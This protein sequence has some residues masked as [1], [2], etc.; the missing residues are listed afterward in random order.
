M[1]TNRWRVGRFFKKA[2]ISVASRIVVAFAAMLL[3]TSSGQAQID[4]TGLNGTVTDA[5]GRVVPKAH[6]T[7]V[8]DGTGLRRETFSSTNGT[9]DI[10]ELP[11]GHYTVTFTS[12]GFE[13]LTYSNVI[14]AV[15]VTRTLNATLK[16][17]GGSQHIQ[18][19]GT[20]NELNETSASMGTRIERTQT[21]DLPLNGRNWATLTLLGPGATDTG[22]SGQRTIHVAGRSVDDNSYTFDG[23][24]ASNVMNQPQQAFVRLAIP[25]DTIEEFRVESALSTAETGS[26]PGG[27]IAVTSVAGSN[28]FHGDAFEYL[29]NDALDARNFFDFAGLQKYPFRLNQFGGSFGGPIK[30]NKTF[31]Y[32]TYEGLRQTLG[33][34]LS[35]FVPTAGYRAQLLAASP[36]LAPIINAY[37]QGQTPVASDP[38][39]IA[40][41]TGEGT[42]LDQ[43]DSFMIRVD[44]HF[45]DRT[46]MYGRFNWDSAISTVPLAGQTGQ[47]LADT[48]ST[49][50][51]PVNSVVELLHVF[52]ADLVN[53]TK[54]G[55][56]RS[57]VI[58]TNEN[59]DGLAYSVAV[60]NLTTENNGSQA[61]SAGNEFSTLDD[62][63]WIRGRH[64]L[65]LGAE[66]RRIQINE[67]NNASGSVTYASLLAFQTNQVSS[68]AFAAALPTNGLRKTS[69]FS[70][71]QDEFKLR[72]NI[73]LDMGLRYS[74]FNHFHEVDGRAIPFDFA[75]CGAQGFCPIGAD[76]GP[77]NYLDLDPRFSIAWAPSKLGRTAVIRAGAGIY[78]GDGQL[79]DQN[80]PESNEVDSYSLSLKTIPTLSFPITPFLANTPGIVSPKDEDR[81]RK[82]MYVS[83][84]GLS[85]EHGVP[86][87]M[88]VTVSYVGEQGTHLLNRSFVNVI[89]PLTGVRPYPAFGQIQYRGNDNNSSFE[90]LQTSLRR[91]FEHGLLLS[92]NYMWSHEID[93]DSAGAG[94]VYSQYPENVACQECERASGNF[95]IRH[96]FNANL[97]YSLPSP[98][99]SR[100]AMLHRIFGS[101][102]LATIFTVR[103][104]L[105]VNV[106]VDRSSSAMPDGNSSSPERPNILPGVS[107]T[108]T[109]GSTI[110]DWINLA[111]FSVPA[112][113]TW[114]D[115]P[116]NAVRGPGAWQEDL[117]LEKRFVVNERLNFQF[118]AEAFNIF[119][120]PEFS[121]PQADISSTSNF[122]QI[123]TTVNTG[124]VGTGTSR[125]IQLMLRG[126]F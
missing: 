120:H 19:S 104:G 81:A 77:R 34:P 111:A 37:P 74:F 96:S 94:G 20:S 35:G 86:H 123:L 5:S 126:N 90:A 117:S 3:L 60:P 100:P 32:A 65:K 11:V 115:A 15:G 103:T 48:Q 67:G 18:V 102:E 26:T 56:N 107:L 41:W 83:E 31:F 69:F 54:F 121:A 17:A 38:S 22:G 116:R 84:W 2:L 40:E 66:I 45:T 82:D 14:Q 23:M 114:G 43:E 30:T 109:S 122:G 8:Q 93:D 68:A 112:A 28:K 39:Q 98:G 50:S 124:P 52:S 4:R 10:P 76:F 78:H 88:V 73:T 70:Y 89:N 36:A 91:T 105:P 42:Q 33:Q 49:A 87:D 113:G 108:P 9:Y 13:D 119:N 24:D 118:R 75:T 27:Q 71:V 61:V 59:A 51:R 64:V 85:A 53:E 72:S 101:W 58:K 79:D 55:F 62:V 1:R 106:T 97:V 110:S 47:Y 63:T 16:V 125:Q 44:H 25:T 21:Q 99:A 7:A 57:T 12:D 6:V 95:D 29:R 46:T 80:F 92:V